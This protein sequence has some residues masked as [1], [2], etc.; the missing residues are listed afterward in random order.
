[1]D[2]VRREGESKVVER[3]AADAGFKQELITNPAAAVAAETGWQ[4]PTNV[5][6]KVV[7]ETADTYYLVIPHSEKMEE[8]ELSDDQL[9]A[10]A[11][12]LGRTCK[13]QTW[14]QICTTA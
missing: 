6:V 14:T 11:G 13:R 3:A 12:G 4:I 2:T 9:E 1:M 8:G 5:T 7:E 10:V